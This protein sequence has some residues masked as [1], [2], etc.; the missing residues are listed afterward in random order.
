M[1]VEVIYAGEMPYTGKSFSAPAVSSKYSAWAVIPRS[2][3]VST[4][5]IE[6]V[7]SPRKADTE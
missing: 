4:V 1:D 7:Y 6:H 5:V 2:R 3:A